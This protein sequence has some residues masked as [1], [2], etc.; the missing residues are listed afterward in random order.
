MPINN[1]DIAKLGGLEFHARQ[2]VEGF[3]AGIHKSPFH[4]F[5]VEFAEHR[6]YNSGEPIR[7]IDW[8]LY[9]RTEKL[10]VKRYEEETNLRC[11]IVID[12]SSSMFFPVRQN[13]GINNPNKLIFSVYSAASLIELMRRQRDAVGLVLFDNNIQL[14]TEAKNSNLHINMIY[15]QLEKLLLPYNKSVRTTTD[16]ASCLHNIADTLH[17]RSLVIVFSDMLDDVSNYDRIFPALEHLRYN[18]HEVILFHVSD[19]PKEYNLEFENRPYRFV[20]LESGDTIKLNPADVKSKYAGLM[21]SKNEE[22]LRHCHQYHID[23]VNADI[24]SFYDQVL[25]TY[26]IKR[27]KLYKS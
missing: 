20:D 6:L 13:N 27:E 24:N 22:L 16:A 5:S 4:G 15:S 18:N 12:T 8:K 7:N 11:Q 14:H 10:F 3:M 2:I 21:K 23:Y 25:T 19:G 26:L 17:K 9:G 1:N